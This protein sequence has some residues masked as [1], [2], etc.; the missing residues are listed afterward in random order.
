MCKN[1]KVVAEKAVLMGEMAWFCGED[2]G[3]GKIG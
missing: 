2:R 1:G 3:E